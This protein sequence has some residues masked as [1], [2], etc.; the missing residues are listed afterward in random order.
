MGGDNGTAVWLTDAG[1]VVGQADLPTSPPGCSGPT[2]IHHAFLWEHGVVTDLGTLG[3]DPCS[4][5]LMMNSKG[6]IVGTTIAICG[7]HE[8][9]AFLWENGGPM[10]D[11]NALIPE[12]SGVTLY[13]ADSINERGEIIASGLPA[14]CDDRFACGRVFLLIPCDAN[15]ASGCANADVSTTAVAPSNPAPVRK[16]AT[17]TQQR[18]ILSRALAGWRARLTQRYHLFGVPTPKD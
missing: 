8:T 1:E 18:P 17:A 7:G 5:A 16:A 2:C 13:E 6:Q 12:D 4:R 15:Y 3:T 11:L 10:V 14:G 9:H